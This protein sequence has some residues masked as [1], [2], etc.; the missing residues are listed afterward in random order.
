[1]LKKREQEVENISNG[2]DYK[3]IDEFIRIMKKINCFI[4][5]SQKQIYDIMTCFKKTGCSCNILTWTKTN[6]TPLGSL[7][8]LNDIEY[9]L[10]FYK[11]AGHNIGAKYKH[12]NYSAPINVKDK[13][14]YLHPTIKPLEMV[15]KHLQ[16]V[17][18]ENDIVLDCFLGSGT[19]AVACKETNRQYLGFEINKEYYDIACDRLKEITQKDKKLKKLGITDIFDYLEE[20]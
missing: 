6:P 13:K 2:I 11:E 7:L 4:W 5:C 18:K 14:K 8:W 12:K 3:I 9:C 16:N 20:E 10:H 19:T 17:T 15:K 1:M